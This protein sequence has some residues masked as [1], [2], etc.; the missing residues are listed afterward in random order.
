MVRSYYDKYGTDAK[1][2]NILIS[3]DDLLLLQVAVNNSTVIRY[4]VERDVLI[5][6][7]TELIHFRKDRSLEWKSD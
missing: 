7:L 4:R 6:I 1:G 5:D 3:D 2:D